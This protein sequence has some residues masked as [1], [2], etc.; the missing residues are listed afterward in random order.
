[1]HRFQVAAL[2]GLLL[3]VAGCQNRPKCVFPTR[4]ILRPGQGV[5]YESWDRIPHE[6]GPG[7]TVTVHWAANVLTVNGFVHRPHAPPPPWKVERLRQ[8]YGDVPFIRDYVAIATG[9][10]VARWNEASRELEV[11]HRE[12]YEDTIDV[13]RSSLGSQGSVEQATRAAAHWLGQSAHVDSV[14]IPPARQL[15]QSTAS[16]FDTCC[17]GPMIMVYWKGTNDG[18]GVMLRMGVSERG[19]YKHASSYRDPGP[20]KDQAC[21]IVSIVRIGLSIPGDYRVEFVRGN[22]NMFGSAGPQYSEGGFRSTDPQYHD[23]PYVDVAPE[24]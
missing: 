5:L 2:L 20:S 22:I 4:F 18:S 7:D 24:P 6:F 19:G 1:M 9:D 16:P 10:S 11:L 17:G 23:N 12:L 8:L 21:A 3:F 14:T 15:P 13:Y